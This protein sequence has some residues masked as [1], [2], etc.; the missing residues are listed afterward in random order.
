MIPGPVSKLTETTVA[1]AATIDAK[2]DVVRLTGT[3]TV[4]T[5]RPGLGTAQGQ[6]LVLVPVDGA[7][8]LG[9]SGNVLV[10]IACAQNRSVFL[11]FVKSLGKWVINSGV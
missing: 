2:S 4:N 5:I 3:T 7:V 8:T 10:G 9:T 11:V 1:S 6:F